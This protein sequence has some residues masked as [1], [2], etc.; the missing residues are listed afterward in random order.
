MRPPHAII[1]QT[2]GA[3]PFASVGRGSAVKGVSPSRNGISSLGSDREG[4]GTMRRVLG[5]S[6]A[7]GG[8]STTASPSGSAASRTRSPSDPLRS[9]DLSRTKKRRSTGPPGTVKDAH[10]RESLALELGL[11][12][13]EV[14]DR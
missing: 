5:S 13:A 11:H 10:D 9:D 7:S 1:T 2:S 8:D 14:D 3:T 6:I 4:A 12:G